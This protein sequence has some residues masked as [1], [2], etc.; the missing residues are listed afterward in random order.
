MT[1]TELKIEMLNEVIK[2]V[3]H[4]QSDI[5]YDFE[6]LEIYRNRDTATFFWG[7]R[8]TGTDIVRIGGTSKHILETLKDRAKRK[9]LIVK[10]VVDGEA[11]WDILKP[12]DF[13]P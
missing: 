10:A 2:Y 1:L 3:S 6:T 8:D 12:E 9:Y 5:V 7:L 11:D 4:Y 13:N